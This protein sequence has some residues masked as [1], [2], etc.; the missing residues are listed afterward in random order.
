[1]LLKQHVCTTFNLYKWQRARKREKNDDI[2]GFLVNNYCLTNWFR[3]K[4][5]TLAMF[6]CGVVF[7][8]RRVFICLSGNEFILYCDGNATINAS[9]SYYGQVNFQQFRNIR[10]ACDCGCVNCLESSSLSRSLSLVHSLLVGNLYACKES[11]YVQYDYIYRGKRYI[12]LHM[13]QWCLCTCSR[14]FRLF[15]IAVI[16]DIAH[17]LF[18]NFIVKEN[19]ERAVCTMH[20]EFYSNVESFDFVRNDVIDVIRRLEYVQIVF[21]L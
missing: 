3:D 12:T 7:I 8:V 9:N 2:N 15:V 17:C 13:H 4:C 1:M 20:V 19:I 6:S 10:R 14:S 5:Y 16:I 18:K 11:T 21:A